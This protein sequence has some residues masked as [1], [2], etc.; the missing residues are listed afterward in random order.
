MSKIIWGVNP[1][2][3]ALKSTPD[4]V[5]EIIIE[6][7]QLKGKIYQ[8]LERAKKAGILVKVYTKEPF[9]PPKVPPHANTQGI[10]AYLREFPYVTLE[11]LVSNYQS[12]VE[13]PLLLALDEVED[14]QNFGSILRL[15][16]SA[17]V[18]GVI[19]PKH[20][21]CQVTGTVIKVSSGSAFNV[22]IARVTNLKEALLFFKERGI[23]IFGLTPHA[24][25]TIY[26][27]DLRIPLL[28]I[29]GNEERGIKPSILKKCDLLARIP[30]RGKVESLNVAQA[31]GIVL[32]E[33]LRQRYYSLGAN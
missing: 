17:G 26:Q 10:V 19:I 2:L 11:D 23:W 27:I 16:D 28:I 25:K 21:S 30:M 24:E 29:A 18:H 14:P 5:E 6:K 20:R 8:I 22:P 12:L 9:H 1:V 15:A 7:R 4:L 13:T 31:V 3:E 32:F 33:V